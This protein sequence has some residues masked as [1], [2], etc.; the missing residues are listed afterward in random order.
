MKRA[1]TEVSPDVPGSWWACDYP[2]RPPDGLMFFHLMSCR[3]CL[4]AAE[5]LLNRV[6]PFHESVPRWHRLIAVLSG[7]TQAAG[8]DDATSSREADHG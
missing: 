3:G 6:D 5:V 1:M 4:V 8:M 2:E 7:E